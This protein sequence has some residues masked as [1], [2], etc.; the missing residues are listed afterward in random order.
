VQRSSDGVLLSRQWGISA[1]DAIVPGDYDGDGTTDFA[2]FRFTTG[3]WY[4]LQSSNGQVRSQQF[5]AN[6]DQ[7]VPGDY[8]GDGKTDFAVVRNSGNLTWYASQSSNNTVQVQQWGIG[9]DY[10]V[11]TFQT[12]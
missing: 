2:V 6:G 10:A 8:D 11:P 7:A 4:V 3:V 12:R 5:G 1:N 9:S